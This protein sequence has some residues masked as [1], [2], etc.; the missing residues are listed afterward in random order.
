MS[1][2]S[3][4][5]YATTMIHGEDGPTAVFVAGNCEGRREK[6]PVRQRVKHGINSVKNMC[7]KIRRSIAE[8]MIMR[9]RPVPHTMDELQQ[10]IVK[11]YV[12]RYGFTE[13]DKNSGEAA[14][15]YRDMRASF[16]IQYAPELLSS[17]GSG[18][19]VPQLKSTSQEDILEYIRLNKERMERAASVPLEKFDIDYHKY[20]YNDM[21]KKDK[22]EAKNCSSGRNKRSLGLNAKNICSLGRNTRSLG[23]M[24]IIIEKKYGY[25]G[26][27]ASGSKKFIKKYNRILRDIHM[28]YGVTTEDIETKSQ[29]YRELVNA[30]L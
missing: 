20:V 29:R 24:D 16:I 14:E 12:G 9:K 25:I 27:G 30:M 21:Y 3:K 19:C 2:R 4:K 13:A 11:K 22:T 8:R 17:A 10:Y 7:W 1:K 26:G 15:E 28:Y 6:L 5:A 18:D 23:S